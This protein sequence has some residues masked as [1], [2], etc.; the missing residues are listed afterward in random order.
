ML[1]SEW[2]GQL[3]IPLGKGGGGSNQPLQ[4]TSCVIKELLAARIT[5]N[6]PVDPDQLQ[7]T[8]STLKAHLQSH[9]PLD[10]KLHLIKTFN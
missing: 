8:S 6:I 7:S 3:N 9:Y 5:N 1:T 2:G 4:T 10:E